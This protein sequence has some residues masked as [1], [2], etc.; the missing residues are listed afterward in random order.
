MAIG[1]NS[2][3]IPGRGS[4]F[5]A[6][7]GHCLHARRAR[8]GRGHEPTDFGQAF[9]GWRQLPR[10]SP[11][12]T[13]SDL[14]RGLKDHVTRRV[15]TSGLA[16]SQREHEIAAA[17]QATTKAACLTVARWHEEAPA[18]LPDGPGAGPAPGQSYTAPRC[19]GGSMAGDAKLGSLLSLDSKLTDCLEGEAEGLGCLR[20]RLL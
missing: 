1:S 16:G 17:T 10:A 12:R 4:F 18:P 9:L 8:D 3:R 20:T 11:V 13:R 5:G 14:T 2:A 6:R 15:G 19:E 7:R